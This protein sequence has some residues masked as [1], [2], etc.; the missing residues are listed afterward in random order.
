MAR[1]LS[2]A[3]KKRVR[4]AKFRR[5]ARVKGRVGLEMHALGRRRERHARQENTP[6]WPRDHAEKHRAAALKGWRKRKGG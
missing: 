2:S 3:T 1:R 6:K 4:L 5:A